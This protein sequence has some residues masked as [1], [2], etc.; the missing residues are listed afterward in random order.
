MVELRHMLAMLKELP[1]VA[2]HK[3]ILGDVEALERAME[4]DFFR[5]VVL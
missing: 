2:G 3:H 4:K 1:Y 5:V